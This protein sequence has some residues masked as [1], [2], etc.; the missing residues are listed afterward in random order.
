MTGSRDVIT[1]ISLECPNV[2]FE[3]SCL[4]SQPEVCVLGKSGA[5]FVIPKVNP[6]DPEPGFGQRENLLETKPVII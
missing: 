6:Q 1:C 4:V 3:T 2:Q 5:A